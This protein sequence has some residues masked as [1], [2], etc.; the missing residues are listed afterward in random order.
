MRNVGMIDK[1]VLLVY[2]L[3]LVYD[4]VSL[5]KGDVSSKNEGGTYRK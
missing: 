1:K 5:K 4:F 2:D 3:I